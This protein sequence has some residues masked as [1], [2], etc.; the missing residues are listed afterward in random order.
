MSV[1]L[2]ELH[3]KS[4]PF[5]WINFLQVRY[6][7]AGRLHEFNG[8]RL[9]WTPYQG[10]RLIVVSSSIFSENGPRK[11]LERNRS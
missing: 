6:R 4:C 8:A 3:A 5:K 2:T 11:M 9:S 10:T 1:S 7:E